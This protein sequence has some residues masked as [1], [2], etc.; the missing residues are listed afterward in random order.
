MKVLRYLLRPL[1]QFLEDDFERKEEIY[2]YLYFERSGKEKEIEAAIIEGGHNV[3]IVGEPGSGKTSLIH[4]VFINLKKK[5]ENIFPII[6]DYRNIVPRNAKSLLKEF[7]I[8]ARK[9][10]DEIDFPINS[11]T[12]VTNLD[13]CEDHSSE[14]QK[15]LAKIPLSKL[16]KKMVILLD[17]L[18]YS[19]QTY[20]K[21]LEEYFLPYTMN[22]KTIVVLSVREPLLNSLRQLDIL[23]LY[24]SQYPREIKIPNDDIEY[25]LHN[26]LKCLYDTKKD[27]EQRSIKEKIFAAFK[28]KSLDEI[29][30]KKLLEIEPDIFD[31]DYKLPFNDTFYSKITH[32][33]YYNF[34]IIEQIIPE[35]LQ[36]KKSHPEICISENFYN[37]FIE[38]FKDRPNILQNL[39]RDKTRSAK[40]KKNNN[41]VLQIVLEYFYFEE[42]ANNYFY[43]EMH[44]YGISKEEC[45][46]SIVTLVSTPYSMLVPDFIYEKKSSMKETVIKKF[47]INIKGKQYVENILSNENYYLIDNFK[48]S[49]RS[50]YEEN[51][52]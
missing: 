30:I 20:I 52:R 8:N 38:L 16:T 42:V 35:F 10:F 11:I 50:Y 48:K 46:K 25:I 28:R 40:K 14:I 1:I 21:I 34:R 24:Y 9:Y 18:D 29:L 12:N 39:T 26:R 5:Y 47:K 32:I 23:R 22:P 3:I 43:E 7:V 44:S 6:L 31:I 4:F 36:Y 17:D 51:R 2:Q 41:N 37:I 27:L 45:D 13:N 33:T 19:E 15:H 49:N